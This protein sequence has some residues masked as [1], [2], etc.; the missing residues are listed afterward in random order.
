[1]FSREFLLADYEHEFIGKNQTR[2]RQELGAKRTAAQSIK[3][4][5][6]MVKAC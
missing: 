6:G 1:M 4:F 2:E 5:P 3:V